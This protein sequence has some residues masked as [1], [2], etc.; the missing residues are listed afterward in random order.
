MWRH[1]A[2]RI[3]IHPPDRSQARR[4]SKN[5]VDSDRSRI[6]LTGCTLFEQRDDLAC[7]A[8]DRL[9][10]IGFARDRDDEVVDPRIDH[11]LEPLSDHLRRPHDGALGI[12]VVWPI[13]AYLRS[14]LLGVGLVLDE[15]DLR[16][17]GLDN[18]LVVAADILAVALKHIELVPDR[19]DVAH[20]V[21]GVAPLR[22]QPERDPLAAAPD[23][24]RWMRLLDALWLVDRPVDR[25][26]LALKL[27]EVLRP[28]PVDD[29]ARFTEH[30]HPVAQLGEAIAVSPP[31]MLVPARPEARIQPAMASNVYRRGDLG[32]QRR[33]TVAVTAN[34]L[35]DLDVLRIACEGGGDRPALE[36]GLELWHGHGVEVVEDPDRVPPSLIRHACDP[37]H[38]LVLLD[39]VLDLG[40]VHPPSLWYEDSESDWHRL[41]A[42]PSLHCWDAGRVASHSP[43]RSVIV[44]S[45]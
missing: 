4:E 11:R 28:H 19:L 22:Y 35:P 20:D 18:L 29:L 36:A 33:V 27:R 45:A 24:E 5:C 16:A 38:R 9:L 32:V 14:L 44:E 25:I 12:F 26:V 7:E 34:H 42:F 21:A 43:R 40:Q 23:P 6:P 17:R 37:R 13:T 41:P 39:R 31:L 1:L 3:S 8:P 30:A 15:V 10:V 2:R